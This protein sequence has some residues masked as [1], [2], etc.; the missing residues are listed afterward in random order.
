MNHLKNITVQI[1]IYQETLE[2][3]SKCL[4]NLKKFKIIILDNANNLRLKNK[5]IKKYEIQKYILEKKNIG[6]SKAHNKIAS[7]VD[8]D[9]LLILNPDCI[10]DE[11]NIINL[12]NAHKNYINCGITGPTTF[13]QNNA[14]TFNGGFLPE[15]GNKGEP[16]ILDGDVCFQ[17]ILGS[18]MLLRKKDFL[19]I[20]MFNEKLF[21]FFSDD[22][23]CRKFRNKK[24]SVI[25]VYGSKAVHEHGLS[26]VRNIFKR[27]FLREF[28][29]IYD[30][31]QYFFICQSHQKKFAILKKKIPSYYA[32]FFLNLI[33]FNF[34]K[35]L[36]YASRIMAYNKF[37]KEL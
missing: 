14:L 31:L 1:V 8:T 26:K 34:K 13:N 18:A 28:Y 10:I 25:Q 7:Y 6:Y 33:I 16:T 23:L 20:G 35:S 22:D 30:E 19:D 37:K 12:Y 32:K 4:S 27:V 24:K 3:V 29:I 9:Y 36:L 11:K 17:S 5:L 2:T 15:N 21:L